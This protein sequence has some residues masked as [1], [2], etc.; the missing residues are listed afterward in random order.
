MAPSIY[1]IKQNG[2]ESDIKETLVQ[3]QNSSVDLWS[4]PTVL[5]PA[6]V[7]SLCLVSVNDVLVELDSFTM[8][9]V[10]LF[11]EITDLE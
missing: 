1:G 2:V 10:V 5:I 8:L 3:N 4:I 11:F 9:V 6:I 7:P